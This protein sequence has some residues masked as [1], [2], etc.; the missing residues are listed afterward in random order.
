MLL[1]KTSNQSNLLLEVGQESGEDYT[2][3][4][5]EEEYQPKPK[6]GSGHTA[7]N[8]KV[9]GK[10]QKTYGQEKTALEAVVE[11][12]EKLAGRLF[13]EASK[14]PGNLV[15]SPSSVSTVLAMVAMGATGSTRD[16]LLTGLALPDQGVGL[17]Y[18]QLL[19]NLSSNNSFTLETANRIYLQ[20]GHPATPS[21]QRELA[22]NF[23][24][25]TAVTNFGESEKSAK[26]INDWVEEK[27][28]N[29]IKDLINPVI[30]N[31]DTRMVLINAIYFKAD[32]KIKFDKRNTEQTSFFSE[33]KEVNV[34]MM[35]VKNRFEHIYLK[36]L[37][38][39]VLRLPYRND[40]VVMEILLPDARGGLKQV[41]KKLKSTNIQALLK[42]NK[43]YNSTMNVF[44]PKFKLETTLPLNDILKELGM[45]DMFNGGL[46]GITG[47][48]DLAVSSVLQKAFIEVTEEGAEAAAATAVVA[49]TRSL[50]ITPTFMANHPFLFYLREAATGLLLF[51]GR[52]AD[53]SQGGQA[54]G[55]DYI[56]A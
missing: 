3:G 47:D 11:G 1:V 21:F 33:L 35:H 7:Y 12:N 36:E 26:L 42:Q 17:G 39:Q 54:L 31:K 27:T 41:E 14:I 32:W 40:K 49:V 34:A 2:N 5:G 38:S 46:E 52:V 20:V 15:L 24:A 23:L 19:P 13:L 45:T 22:T 50:T 10:R 28:R 6:I 25:S 48:P 16:Q 37:K 8:P 30:L 55:E 9:Y 51:Q 56:V 18:R 43:F 44:L 4:P 53:P 29:K